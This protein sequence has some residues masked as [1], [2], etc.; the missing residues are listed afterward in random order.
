MPK[1]DFVEYITKDILR[2]LSGITAKAMF[3]GVSI[4]SKGK[5]FAIV[6][7]NVLYFK[8]DDSNRKDYEGVGSAPF[9]YQ[10]KNGP[11]AMSY[12][13]VP[14]EIMEDPKKCTAWAEKSLAIHKKSKS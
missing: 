9:T 11:V 3:G 6:V 7:D 10:G 2:N 4:Y 1:N 8:V 14:E 5:I 12:W 13:R